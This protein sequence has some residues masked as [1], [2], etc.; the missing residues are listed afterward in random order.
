MRFTFTLIY[1]SPLHNNDQYYYCL[2]V[3][4]YL[5][6]IKI[7]CSTVEYNEKRLSHPPP[8]QKSKNVYALNEGYSKENI[9]ST[10]I[11]EV[12]KNK[13]KGWLKTDGVIEIALGENNA[14][15]MLYKKI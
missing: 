7:G 13:L 15:F 14:L 11:S 8:H 4:L 3:C 10:T 5:I 1:L 9:I 12:D 2:Y 6:F